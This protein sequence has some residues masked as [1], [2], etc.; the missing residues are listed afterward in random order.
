M[1]PR[2][3]TCSPCALR[4][5]RRRRD[6]RTVRRSCWARCGSPSAGRMSH[7]LMSTGS[8][9]AAMP[10]SGLERIPATT[11]AGLVSRRVPG[12]RVFVVLAA[13]NPLPPSLRRRLS[14]SR[15]GV[16]PARDEPGERR[17]DGARSKPWRCRTLPMRI[18]REHGPMCPFTAANL[19]SMM[20]Q[21]V[22][23]CRIM[24]HFNPRF[25]RHRRYKIPSQRPRA[26]AAKQRIC[27]VNV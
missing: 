14:G 20:R 4:S 16:E 25:R 23:D 15:P 3:G 22:L 6:A 12:V 1:R 2:A 13:A 27:G 5:V 8:D 17:G 24:R 10:R 18:A 19:R 21:S 9:T 26:D 11:A 7:G